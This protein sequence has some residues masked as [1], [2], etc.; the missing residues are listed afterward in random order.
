MPHKTW[1]FQSAPCTEKLKSLTLKSSSIKHLLVFLCL[2]LVLSACGLYSFSGTN[3][4][5]DV[6]SISVQN[7]NDRSGTG[8]ASLSQNFSE[9]LRDYYQRNTQLKIVK[10]KGDLQVSG[11]ITGYALSP[12]APTGNQVSAQ[13]RLTIT[14]SVKYVNELNE[15]DNFERSFSFF[16]DFPQATSLQTVESQLISEISDQLILDIFNATV[17]NW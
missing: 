11:A 15:G 8:P 12:V 2:S 9:K 4:S 7:F 1:A 6:K 10:T 16:K 17:A 5:P 3:I 14:V 13:T